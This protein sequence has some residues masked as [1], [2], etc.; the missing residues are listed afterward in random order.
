[1]P[2]EAGSKAAVPSASLEQLSGNDKAV[3][4]QDKEKDKNI[5]SPPTLS[6]RGTLAVRGVRF[7][8]LKD[9]DRDRSDRVKQLLF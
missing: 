6:R 4:G 1:M 9:I 2:Q 3:D 7:T 8:L 5:P